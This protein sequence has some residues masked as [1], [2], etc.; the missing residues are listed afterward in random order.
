M[1]KDAIAR[2]EF[3]QIRSGTDQWNVQLDGRVVARVTERIIASP[4]YV[5]NPIVDDVDVVGREARMATRDEVFDF[6]VNWVNEN[7]WA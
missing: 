5:V 6:I 7:G 2:L 1:T 3:I 4:T